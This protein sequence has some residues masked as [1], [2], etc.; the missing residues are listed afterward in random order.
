MSK[1]TL[2]LYFCA[3]IK[4]EDLT[5]NEIIIND[6]HFSTKNKKIKMEISFNKY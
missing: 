2:T 6:E 5:F 1:A 4:Y 3:F